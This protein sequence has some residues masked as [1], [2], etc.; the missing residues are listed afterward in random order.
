MAPV[1]YRGAIALVLALIAV[2]A[3]AQLVGRP[4]ARCQSAIGKGGFTFKAK[5]ASTSRKCYD[6]LLKGGPCDTAGRDGKI[7]S[8]ADHYGIVMRRSCT[9]AQL[10]SAPPAGLGFALSCAFESGAPEPA[11]QACAALPVT[12]AESLAR[13]LACW[14]QAE[15]N[16]LLT[17]GYPCL[18]GQIPAGSDLDCGTPPACPVD[19][20]AIDCT[21]GIAKAALR[22]VLAKEQALEKCLNHVIRGRIPGPCP[23][24]KTQALIA[25]AEAKVTIAALRCNV[26][27]PWWDVCPEMCSQSISTLDD[28]AT[29]IGGSA[30]AITDELVCIQYPSASTNGIT[31]P[32]GDE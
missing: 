20:L 26:N 3:A 1:P 14:K 11:E 10:F 21:R 18:V 12:D 25:A 27:P 22:F 4:A 16:E 23:D 24:G 19:K 32:P 15:L 9:P 7:A 2:P 6:A 17:I 8:A 29:C 5:V 31:C 13:C 30:E 28:I